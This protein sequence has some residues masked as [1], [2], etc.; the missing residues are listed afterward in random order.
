MVIS[1]A[2]LWQ[3]VFKVMVCVLGAVQRV[4]TRCTAPSTHTT[5]SHNTAKL[6]T[7]YFY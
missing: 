5:C 4:V 7:M 1:F 3:H 6:I 2:L